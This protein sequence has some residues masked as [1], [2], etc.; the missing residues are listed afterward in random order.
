MEGEGQQREIAKSLKNINRQLSQLMSR[1]SQ[2][3]PPRSLPSTPPTDRTRVH[4]THSAVKP[5]LYPSPQT[6][7][8]YIVCAS[9]AQL[10]VSILPRKRV[11]QVRIPPGTVNV[12]LNNWLLGTLCVSLFAFLS[13]SC[14]ASLMSELSCTVQVI[15]RHTESLRY[16]STAHTYMC[17]DLLIESQV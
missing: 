11:L 13:C 3:L 8:R 1:I 7:T 17:M 6:T 2:G 15:Q 16:P 9:V 4:Y 10:R 14:Q 5:H 12:S